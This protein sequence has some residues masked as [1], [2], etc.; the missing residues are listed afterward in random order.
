MISWIRIEERTPEIGDYSVLVWF[1][2]DYNTYEG[3]C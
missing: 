1:E 2:D 3:E